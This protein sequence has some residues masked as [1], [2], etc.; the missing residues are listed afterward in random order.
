M[1][2][3]R[4]V[5]GTL[6]V[7]FVRYRR[8]EHRHHRIA[9][10]LLDERIEPLDNPAQGAEQVG[11]Q[12]THIFGIQFLRDRRES[13]QV[14]KQHGGQSTIGITCCDGSRCRRCGQLV[15]A[16]GTKRKGD[17]HIELAALAFH[18]QILCRGAARFRRRAPSGGIRSAR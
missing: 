12:G 4:R 3:E 7:V 17:R 5:Q 13:G 16:A 6:R 11:L 14:R 8:A 10:E 2:L 15:S 9:D 1:H 18:Q